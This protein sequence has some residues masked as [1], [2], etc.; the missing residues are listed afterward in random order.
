MKEAIRE[1]LKMLEDNMEMFN[2]HALQF[3][4]PKEVKKLISVWRWYVSHGGFNPKQRKPKGIA[5]DPPVPWL[6]GQLQGQSVPLSKDIGLCIQPKVH[7]TIM[8][9]HAAR[10]IR[11]RLNAIFNYVTP[12]AAKADQEAVHKVKVLDKMTKRKK[13]EYDKIARERKKLIPPTEAEYAKAAKAYLRLRKK[14]KK[15]SA[16]RRELA[17]AETLLK[18]DKQTDKL[19]RLE[20]GSKA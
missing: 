12:E 15:E 5:S 11:G 4:D 13:L 1:D 7:S 17:K 8:T 2:T 9:E 10:R 16:N 6:Q 20:S 19:R 14:Q 18:Y 3:I